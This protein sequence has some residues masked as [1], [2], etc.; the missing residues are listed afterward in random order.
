MPLHF[1]NQLWHH[2]SG[3]RVLFVVITFTKLRGPMQS[4]YIGEE[5]RVQFKLREDHIE[6]NWAERERA[7]L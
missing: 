3:S 7:P 2:L 4:L 5:L 6:Y 1:I